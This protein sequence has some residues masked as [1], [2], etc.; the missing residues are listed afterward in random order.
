[1]INEEHLKIYVFD[2]KKKKRNQLKNWKIIDFLLLS[3]A[4]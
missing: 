3:F 4:K 1:M 2:S